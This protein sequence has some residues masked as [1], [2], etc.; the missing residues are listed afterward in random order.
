MFKA[1]GSRLFRMDGG[2]EECT[3][4]GEELRCLAPPK[5]GLQWLDPLRLWKHRIRALLSITADLADTSTR[6][7]SGTRR[8]I[9]PGLGRFDASFLTRDPCKVPR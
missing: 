5:V 7:I 8:S 2:S 6:G 4:C 1:R 9:V 3:S